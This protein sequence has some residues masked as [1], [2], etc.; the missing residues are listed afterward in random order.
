MEKVYNKRN[1]TLANWS[2]GLYHFSLPVLSRI[3]LDLRSRVI[4]LYT[5]NS[6]WY[7]PTDQHANIIFRLYE[8]I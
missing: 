7:K 3:T 8:W 2:V 6:K 5:G 4:R 1:I